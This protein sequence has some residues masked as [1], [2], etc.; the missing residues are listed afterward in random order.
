MSMDP[1]TQIKRV[2]LSKI[3]CT[4][5]YRPGTGVKCAPGIKA[6]YNNLNTL[7]EINTNVLPI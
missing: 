7:H 1:F 6:D 4:R 3:K 5:V 2:I